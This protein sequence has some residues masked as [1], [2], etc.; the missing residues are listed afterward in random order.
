MLSPR[1]RARS[2]HATAVPR[3][4][5]GRPQAC[6]PCRGRKVGCDHQLP[7]CSRC[8]KGRIE[9]KCIYMV[10]KNPPSPTPPRTR[11]LPSNL[12]SPDRPARTRIVTSPRTARQGHAAIDARPSESVRYEALGYMGATSFSIDLEE[13][14]R[15]L[16]SMPGAEGPV[17]SV[18]PSDAPSLSLRDFNPP[19]A[20]INVIRNIPDRASSY[21]LFETY[22][23]IHDAWCRLAARW[24]LHSLWD[25]FGDILEGDRSDESLSV[26]AKKLC[27]N[28]SSVLREDHKDP[29]EWFNEF[30]GHNMRWECIG[31]LFAYW[32]S[33]LLSLPRETF[34]GSCKALNDMDRRSALEFYKELVA[35]CANLC[36]NAGSGNTLLCFL[37]F[38]RSLLQSNIGG[39]GDIRHFRLHGDL[40]ALTTYLG[41]HTSS[42]AFGDR[43]VSVQIRRRLFAGVFNIDKLI[44]IFT[45]R[46]P[47]LSRRFISVSEPLDISD[48]ELL[49]VPPR[50]GAPYAGIDRAGWSLG[51]K[52]LHVSPL[53]ARLM[54]A[55]TRDSILEIA[56]RNTLMAC[57]APLLELKQQ[58]NRMY[59]G[60]PSSLKYAADDLLNPALDHVQVYTR[61]HITLE[62][63]HNV[64]F[65]E[66]LLSKMQ[67]GV[68]AELV[69][70]SL[71][72]IELSLIPFTNRQLTTGVMCD[73][74]WLLMAYGAPAGGVLCMELLRPA[75]ASSGASGVKKSTMIQSLSMLVGCLNAVPPDAPNYG[76]SATLKK[77]IEQVLDRVLDPPAETTGQEF[78]VEGWETDFLVDAA[79]LFNSDLLDTFDWFRP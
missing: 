4:R 35:D 57:E 41:L 79:D 38:K 59:D 34:K 55:Y 52:I 3:R 42:A 43:S 69:R 78:S 56:L 2:P 49:Q 46:P 23:N 70:I 20:A 29:K 6:E 61:L 14:Q 30:S 13:A 9:H 21:Y 76:V 36:W 5:N 39:D 75:A 47:L 37:L 8:R 77:I 16:M 71:E 53:R 33:G 25:T 7:V 19:A 50:Q 15:R 58:A 74:D 44:A 24:L 26:M 27:R 40:V 63:L 51:N 66:R 18:P 11:E 64:F 54:M 72:I 65:V 17:S 1:S 10:A 62:H 12:P 73:I 28:T 32:S 31:I 60:F 22:R 68:T 45:G 48:E 67:E